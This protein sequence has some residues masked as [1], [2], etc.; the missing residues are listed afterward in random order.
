VS[1][2]FNRRNHN[3]RRLLAEALEPRRLLAV[4]WTNPLVSLDVNQDRSVAP[5]DAL[6]VINDLNRNGP[7]DLPA[8]K[9]DPS[10]PFLDVNRD[11]GVNPID[12]LQI[13]N[14]LNRDLQSGFRL[15][16]GDFLASEFSVIIGVGQS[17]GSRTYRFEID[18][19]LDTS[20]TGAIVEDTLAVYLKN[21][22]DPS[23]RLLDWSEPGAPLFSLSGERAQFVP[24]VV[25]FDG[26][27][28]DLDLS[29]ISDAE[30]AELTFQL[31]NTDHDTESWIKIDLIEN[32]TDS[33]G[34]PATPLVPTAEILQPAT[35]I[36][37]ST[38]NPSSDIRLE[39]ANIRFDANLGVYSAAVRAENSGLAIGRDLAVVFTGLPDGVSLRNPSGMTEAGLPYLSLR[40]AIPSGGL[41]R[42]ELS[43]YVEFTIDVPS[44]Q[45]FILSSETWVGL[46]NRPPILDQV[47]EVVIQPGR[48]IEIPLVASDPDGDQLQFTLTPQAAMPTTRLTSNG[49]LVFSPTPDQVGEYTFDVHVSDGSLK[50]T[51]AVVVRVIEDAV[52]TTRISGRVLN[53]SGTPLIGM[54]VEIGGTQVVTGADGEFTLNLGMGAP[55]SETMRIRGDL[56][57]GDATYPFIAER[58][59]LMLGHEVFVGVD[60]EIVRPIYL[61][62]LDVAGGT[63]VNPQQDTIV[64][65]ELAGSGTASIEIAS[66]TLLDQ[67]GTP[68]NGVL[69]ITEVPT[70]FTPAALPD[71]LF[72]DLVVTIQPGEMVFATPAP[73]TLPNRDQ[74]LPGTTLDLWSINPTTGEF[75]IV[76][77]G[78]VTDDGTEIETISGGIRNSSWHFFASLLDDLLADLLDVLCG[79][80]KA[81]ASTSSEVEL[82]TGTY[83]EHHSLVPYQSLGEQRGLTF[84]YDSQRAAPRPAVGFRFTGSET[85]EIIGDPSTFSRGIYARL[86]LTDKNVTVEAS[87]AEN[88]GPGFEGGENFWVL[89]EPVRGASIGGA[90][91]ADASSLPTGVFSYSIQAGNYIDIAGAISPRNGEKISGRLISVNS[92]NSPY[93]VGWGIAGLKNIVEGDDGSVL[94][95]DGDGSELLFSPPLGDG[96]G[97]YQSPAGDYSRLTKNI[98]GT[99][100][101]HHTDQFVE[102]YDAENRLATLRDRNA[103]ETVFQY[104]A[105]G[106]LQRVIDPTGLATELIYSDGLLSQVIDPIGRAT[107]FHHDSNQNLTR[108]VNP[109]GAERNW[110]YSPENLLTKEITANGYRETTFYDASGRST[111][112]IRADNSEVKVRSR[113]GQGIYEPERTA[114]HEDPPLAIVAP[115]DNALFTD[116]RGVVTEYSL[117][118]AG[119]VTAARDPLGTQ[120]QLERDQNLQVIQETDGRGN[121]TLYE[122]DQRGNRRS[123]ADAIS[124]RGSDRRPAEDFFSGRLIVSEKVD[125]VDLNEEVSQVFQDLDRDGVHEV[126]YYSTNIN[127]WVYEESHLWG[128][129]PATPTNLTLSRNSEFVFGDLNADSFVDVLAVFEEDQER[130]AEIHLSNGKG[131]FAATGRLALP[132]VA[133]VA[134]LQASDV[135][136]DG[137]DDLLV[138]FAEETFGEG[139]TLLIAET[140]AMGTF[141]QTSTVALEGTPATG[142]DYP[143]TD[144]ND[145]G[146]VEVYVAT[147]VGMEVVDMVLGTYT[148]TTVTAQINSS[149]TGDFDGDGRPDIAYSLASL[150]L[151]IR[152]GSEGTTFEQEQENELTVERDYFANCWG[153]RDMRGNGR[154]QLI[155]VTPRRGSD[156]EAAIVVTE[157]SES[158]EVIQVQEIRTDGG[159]PKQLHFADLNGNSQEDLIAGFTDRAEV[160]YA[161]APGEFSSYGLIGLTNI[162]DSYSDFTAA[163]LNTDGQPELIAVEGN[164]AF[165]EGTLAIIGIDQQGNASYIDEAYTSMGSDNPL[166]TV[167]PLVD[168]DV[169]DVLVWDIDSST[170]DKVL[171]FRGNGDGT[172]SESP[173]VLDIPNA[174]EGDALDIDS[175]GILDLVYLRS[176]WIP[177]APGETEVAIVVRKGLGGGLFGDTILTDIGIRKSVSYIG[178][179]DVNND[180]FADAVIS[181]LSVANE[182]SREISIYPGVGDGTFGAARTVHVAEENYLAN[183]V[184]FNFDGV[185]DLATYGGSNGVRIMHGDGEFSF[186]PVATLPDAS[187]DLAF[188]DLN[189]DGRTDVI[190]LT[191]GLYN[192]EEGISVY[193]AESGGTFSSVREY[194]I[195]IATAGFEVADFNGDQVFDI[196]Y[197]DYRQELSLQLGLS[198]VVG[199]TSLRGKAE[200][201]FDEVFS[202]PTLRIDELGRHTVLELDETTGNTLAIVE[203]G[204]I[205]TEW[206]YLNNGLVQSMQDA[207][208]RTSEYQYTSSGMVSRLIVAKGTAEEA[209]KEYEYDEAG[210][211][212]SVTDENG[213]RTDF[214]YDAANRIVRI[215]EPAARAGL[216]RPTTEYSYDSM[217]NMIYRRD[218]RGNEKRFSYDGRDRLI[219]ETDV[220]AGNLVTRYE[221]DASG[222]LV[223]LIDPLG[224]TTRY[225]YDARNRRV[226][227][228]DPEGG[229]TRFRYD[230]NGNTLEIIDPVKNKTR[231]AYDERDRLVSETDPLGATSKF[232][233]DPVD[234]LT[235]KTDRLGRIT[236]YAHDDLDRLITEAW[237]DGGNAIT[238]VYDDVDN[239]VSVSDA[240]SQYIYRY[241]ARNRV[242]SASNTGT[243]DMPLFLLEYTYD[244]IGNVLSV[245]DTVA[246]ESSVTT[247]YEYDGRNQL[248]TLRQSGNT[249]SDKV[250]DFVFNEL[251]QFASVHRYADLNRDTL[252]AETTYEYDVLN[253]IASL[254]HLR[255]DGSPLKFFQYSYDDSGRLTGIEDDLGVSDFAYDRKNQLIS[256]SRGEGD[257]RGDESYFYDDN[258]NRINSNSHGSSYAT[259]AGNRLQSD[260]VFQY[261]YDSEGNIILRRTIDTGKTRTFEWDTRNR[262]VAIED[263][264]SNGHSLFT[265]RYVFDAMGRRLAKHVDFD[266]DGSNAIVSTYFLYEG[267][268]IIYHYVQPEDIEDSE[269]VLRYLHGPGIDSVLS[270]ESDELQWYIADHLGSTYALVGVSGAIGFSTYYDSF[271]VAAAYSDVQLIPNYLFT[272]REYDVES[273]L[274][275]YRS[276]NYEPKIGRFVS[277]DALRFVASDLNL[278]RY[279]GNSPFS[280][281]D[282]TGAIS[283]NDYLSPTAIAA[284][285]NY[286]KKQ[287]LQPTQDWLVNEV[288]ISEMPAAFISHT[289]WGVLFGAG[290]GSLTGKTQGAVFGTFSGVLF[291]LYHTLRA[292]EEYAAAMD[293][294]ERHIIDKL[295]TL[296][297]ISW[298][299]DDF[300][301]NTLLTLGQLDGFEWPDDC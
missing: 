129:L 284:A 73:L 268:N 78:R 156:Y 276:R 113:L 247:Q 87:G 256:A 35:S 179:F 2:Q 232:E 241:D 188:E 239:L 183:I 255:E 165:S 222:N 210:N 265:A 79:C 192:S 116:G 157:F 144:F 130:F 152:F 55:V 254:R 148:A 191:A 1:N 162:S 89:E 180:G 178:F 21:P 99:F 220:S 215:E 65:Q 200:M 131:Q 69:S 197:R 53:V 206:A 279:V 70:D 218:A 209:S 269:L 52:T 104:S 27:F 147:D 102:I 261:D 123:V 96:D 159:S 149:C 187:Y 5:L 228:I 169:L 61:P 299:L 275:Y 298:E 195:P 118:R 124:S 109:E 86:A 240:Y 293:E 190:A 175:D 281:R 63:T 112:S 289:G 264:D 181:S 16:E 92:R 295:I 94:I 216:A 33:E 273:G 138:A 146:T 202:Q 64:A 49:T 294:L 246:G 207:L 225:E 88:V 291:G 142:F 174:V 110:S 258:G 226:T 43:S 198:S 136:G 47:A 23:T 266:G 230:G 262:L 151:L 186:S 286:V 229:I 263:Q 285:F 80:P 193:L 26:R 106:L 257:P 58:L 201:L 74:H 245:I 280:F 132:L 28:V 140:S 260:G 32:V 122:Y 203:P 9:T 119:L 236:E 219:T 233:Y 100:A 223:R 288:G 75:E 184:D 93:G 135:N 250:V 199:N 59:P 12:A 81:T 168:S 67:Q 212:A 126:L 137:T 10:A 283:V 154:D 155:H 103:N 101:R 282:P 117:N 127:A 128:R 95:V 185:A 29:G 267:E 68:F 62:Q 82:F 13:I 34:T 125:A 85:S 54:R 57:A 189:A 301:R 164:K 231:Y 4:G 171:V 271:G 40:N 243:P 227:S 297:P 182:D 98:D 115:A 242:A 107:S 22:T 296:A 111:G 252:V 217:G 290:V 31:I 145:D 277:E 15:R 272:G 24:G 72:T 141:V 17:E 46:P 36:P 60:N 19:A 30:S 6:V 91:F 238:Y 196:A 234:N 153:A 11:G 90:L 249:V 97:A 211:L 292:N 71:N 8:E 244:G 121:V 194:Q 205:R 251:G 133:P 167:A 172:V 139:G 66:G 173:I 224:F 214:T 120:V 42:N 84:W 208:G 150:E 3:K 14:A 18:A 237:V 166:V 274:Y 253:R 270:Q 143:V 248:A 105:S 51:E 38:L 45:S 114:N 259:G 161:T 158:R 300:L 213:N 39:L 204:G 20:D 235:K 37:F 48:Q 134:H 50:S 177:N 108:I 83:L 41:G 77:E 44:N 176:I 221:Y 163:D 170:A 7:R 56:F 25:R 76:G 287:L 160:Y 278:Y